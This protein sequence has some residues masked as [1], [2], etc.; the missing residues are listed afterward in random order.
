[1]CKIIGA[2]LQGLP[3]RVQD[4]RIGNSVR[5]SLKS[6][7]LIVGLAFDLAALFKIGLDADFE[8]MPDGKRFLGER[9]PERATTKT[10]VTITN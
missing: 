8:V 10:V 5:A 9:V 7:A 6:L 1:M 3:T 4:V 2:F